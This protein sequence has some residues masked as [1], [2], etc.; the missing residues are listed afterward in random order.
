MGYG[1]RACSDD[2][3]AMATR[4]KR[5]AERRHEW[6][7]AERQAWE[8]FRAELAAATTLEA[9]CRLFLQRA[10][11]EGSPG[12]RY[13]SNLGNFLYGLTVP[14]GASGAE[15]AMYAELVERLGLGDE[16]AA[17]LRRVARAQA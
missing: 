12:R 17:H 8:I 1:V 10:P 16:L 5:V 14:G 11:P 3:G 4:R 13:Y 6:A 2:A 7:E 15:L 9:A